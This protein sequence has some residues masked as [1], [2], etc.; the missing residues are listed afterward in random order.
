MAKV[1]KDD[2]SG[3]VKKDALIYQ[4]RN[5]NDNKAEYEKLDQKGKLQFFKDYYLKTILIVLAIVVIGGYYILKAVTKPQNILYIAI[6]DDTFDEKQIDQ[7]EQDMETY[8][9]LDGKKEVVSI[10]VDYNHKNGQASH[11]LQSYLYAGSCDIVIA[12]EEGFTGWAEGGYFL[13][14]ESSELVSFYKEQDDADRIYSKI[15]DGEEIRGEKEVDNAEYNF[16]ISVVDCEK[17]KALGG[18]SKT[19]VAGISNSSKHQEEAVAFL[20][21]LL[22]DDIQAGDVNPD[23]AGE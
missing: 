10:N 8:L 5:D 20:Q 18:K 23:F 12:S 2:D 19:A 14:P 15:I 1:I 9:G 3:R 13:E 21:Y 11:Q 7:L 6:A 17:Y 4:K 22:N 16:G